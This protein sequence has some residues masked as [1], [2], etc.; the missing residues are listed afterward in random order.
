MSVNNSQI[1]EKF[2]WSSYSFSDKGKVRKIQEDDYMCNDR[3]AHWVVA[4]GMGGHEKGDVAS[5]LISETLEK[6]ERT[7]LF[8]DF[9]DG[10]EDGLNS[11]NQKLQLMAGNGVI[12]STVAGIALQ[13]QYALFYWA[14]DSRIYLLRDKKLNQL[15]IDHTY[16][17]ELIDQGKLTIEEASEHPQKNIITRAV[18]A[19]PE[20]FIDFEM[21]QLQHGDLFLVCSDGIEKE[22]SND[23]VQEILNTHRKNP[24]K[25]GQAV[26]DEVLERG[27][28]DNVTFVLVDIKEQ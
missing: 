16:T 18:G 5:L 23:D 2:S 1:S 10:I 3:T 19:D 25:A 8:A 28:R 11:V 13:Q 6:L 20:L 26:L 24:Q 9:V 27:A 22:L 21:M 12:G 17:Q 15:S 14:G 4:D 7:A